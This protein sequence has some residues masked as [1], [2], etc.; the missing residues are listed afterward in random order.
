MALL[1]KAA[2][3]IWND[4]RPEGREVFYAW[5]EQEHMA[6]RVGIPGFLRG[7]RYIRIE[8]EIEWLTLYEATSLAV[9]AGPDYQGRL[10]QPTPWTRRAVRE[11]LNVTRGLTAVAASRGKADGGCLL[12]VGLLVEERA[13]ARARAALGA[14]LVDELIALPGVCAAHLAEADRAASRLDTAERRERGAGTELPDAVLLV[15]ASRVERLAPARARIEAAL[16]GLE[17]VAVLRRPGT[18]RLEFQLVK[19]AA[20]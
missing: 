12:A 13:A 16:R 3:T 18:Y 17:G 8:A 4:I 19:P 6:E 1:G 20:G 7:R 15:E 14:P 10:N 11:F 5:H 2:V 9:L